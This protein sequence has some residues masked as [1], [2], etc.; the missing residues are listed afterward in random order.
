MQ[1]AFLWVTALQNFPFFL[2]F[3]TGIAKVNGK[4]CNVL[5]NGENI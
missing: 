3:Q 4:E 2:T 1:H 5:S